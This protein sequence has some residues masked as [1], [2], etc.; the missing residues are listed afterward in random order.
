M[1]CLLAVIAVGETIQ[2]LTD[3]RSLLSGVCGQFRGS[4][5]HLVEDPEELDDRKRGLHV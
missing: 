2:L 4:R 1:P 5:G 3:L